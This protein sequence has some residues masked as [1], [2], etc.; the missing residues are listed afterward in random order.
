MIPPVL[1]AAYP[2]ITDP[3]WGK[4]ILISFSLHI[5]AFSF[6][7]LVPGS[8]PGRRLPSVIYEVDLVEL[9]AARPVEA[10]Q[11]VPAKS[12]PSLPESVVKTPPAVPISKPEKPVVIAKRVIEDKPRPLEK[13]RIDPSKR[14]EQALS[15]LEQEAEA[16]RKRQAEQQRLEREAEA[17]AR[18]HLDQALSNLQ[19]RQIGNEKASGLPD[20]G[21]SLR[22]YQLAVE[23]S[24]KSNWSFPVGVM[25]P[26][27]QRDLQALMVLDVESGGKIL[28]SRFKR[29]SGDD[30]FDQSVL[31]AIERSDPLPP[32]PEGYPKVREEIEINF[33]LSELD[34]T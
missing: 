25:D 31:R 34:R 15:R 19:T 17:S 24:I 12:V 23:E 26:Q 22:L 29:K 13:P 7:L 9:P 10:L 33:N 4:T 6:V 21:I 8:M 5:L 1:Q 11:P 16:K 28:S 20:T 30:L 3:G 14:L 32:F 27:R 18:S 2:R